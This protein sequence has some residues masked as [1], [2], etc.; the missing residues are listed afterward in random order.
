MT[1]NYPGFSTTRMDE[2]VSPAARVAAMA[3]VESATA[4]ALGAAGIIPAEA[5]SAI[6][7]ACRQPISAGILAGGWDSGTPVLGLLDELRGRL[8]EDARPFLHAGLTTQD[9]VD[10]ATMVIASHAMHHLT[11]LGADAALALRRIIERYGDIGTQ[12]RSFLQPAGSTTFGFR[13]ARWLDQLDHTRRRVSSVDLPV[14]LGGLIGDQFGLDASVIAAVASGLGLTVRRPWHTDRGPVIALVTAVTDVA[15]WADKVS[16]DIAQLAQLGEVTT[17]SG[18]SSAA[19]GKRNP[20]DAMRAMAAAEACLGVAT[21]ITNAKPLELERGLG[22]WHAEWF[23]IPI[24]LQTASAALE[25][26]TAALSSLTVE[27]STLQVPADRRQAAN[28]YIAAV[29]QQSPPSVLG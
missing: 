9:V 18:G 29:L 21:I 6:V 1:A 20:I 2:I 28:D 8:P 14:Q 24:V 16:A 5:A 3:G 15:R 12:A 22:A 11:R 13:V 23:A 10:T 7:A 17:R 4:T 26:A 19:A 25:A 27:R